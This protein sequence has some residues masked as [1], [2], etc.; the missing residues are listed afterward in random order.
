[1]YRLP[2][3]FKS[4]ASQIQSAAGGGSTS[5]TCS[6]CVVTA[7]GASV[8]TA[9]HFSGLKKPEPS[10]PEDGDGSDWPAPGTIV[11]PADTADSGP[12]STGRAF[13]GLFSLVIAGAIGG[14]IASSGAFVLGVIAAIGAFIGIFAMAYDSAGLPAGSG[15]ARAVATVI[16]IVVV[17]VIEIAVWTGG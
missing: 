11:P 13:L 9:I 16:G 14:V 7:A 8:L 6:C 12:G 17:A 4:S 15:V 10:T 1:M 5:T 3:Q 2:N